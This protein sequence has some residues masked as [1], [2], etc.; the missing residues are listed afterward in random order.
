MYS[1]PGPSEDEKT[2]SAKLSAEASASDRNFLDI[3]LST[4]HENCIGRLV[5]DPRCGRPPLLRMYFVNHPLGQQ[6]GADRI[7]QQDRVTPEAFAGWEDY[8]V[9]AA[10]R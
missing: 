4:Y 7:W 5:L 2:V 8:P 10:Y 1:L 9:A 6:R 3:D